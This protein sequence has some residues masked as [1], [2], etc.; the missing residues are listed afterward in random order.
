MSVL[1]RSL[2][3]N[4][5]LLYFN[6]A[7][8]ASSGGESLSQIFF[9]A[10]AVTTSAYVV[11]LFVREKTIYSI[12]NSSIVLL[13][14]AT[15]T[16]KLQ[17]ESIPLI[18][19]LGVAAYVIDFMGPSIVLMALQAG[20]N[21]VVFRE[22]YQRAVTVELVGRILAAG[23]VALI[24]KF[25]FTDLYFYWAWVL[26]AIHLISFNYFLRKPHIKLQVV[27]ER[28]TA[29]ARVKQ[30]KDGLRFVASNSLV[31][32]AMVLIVWMNSVKFL[33]EYIF[34]QSLSQNYQGKE[35]IGAFVGNLT[36]V[37]II[38]TLSAQHFFGKKLLANLSL[39]VLLAVIPTSILLFGSAAL[40]GPTFVSLLMLM[41]FFQ[42]AHR[43]IQLPVSRQCFVPVPAGLRKNINTIVMLTSAA[44]GFLISGLMTLLAPWWDLPNFIVFTLFVAAAILLFISNFDSFYVR[45]L[46]SYYRERTDGRW[47][48]QLPIDP[49]LDAEAGVG[50]L[51]AGAPAAPSQ[52]D[53]SYI[54]DHIEGEDTNLTSKSRML[55]LGYAHSEDPSVLKKLMNSHIQLLQSEDADEI[56]AG[57]RLLSELSLPGA[58][59]VFA[60]FMFHKDMTVRKMA[61]V[62][63]RSTQLIVEF[64]LKGTTSYTRRKLRTLILEILQEE[65]ADEKIGRLRQLAR[66]KGEEWLA[67]VIELLTEDK[68]RPL[69]ATILSCVKYPKH[70][71]TLD[72]LLE[73]LKYKSFDEALPLL[74]AFSKMVQSEH[75]GECFLFINRSL[76]GLLNSN[77][78][79]W[80][81]ERDEAMTDE[82]FITLYLQVRMIGEQNVWQL[83]VNTL[84]DL[85]QV[86]DDELAILV[87]MQLEYLKQSPIVR[88]WSYMMIKNPTRKDLQDARDVLRN[89]P[90]TTDRSS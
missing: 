20:S 7:F 21:P 13:A 76:E 80:D 16:F 71:I 4:A 32:V 74:E 65:K 63:Y 43:C 42:V 57:L 29:S 69:R 83:V 27:A 6:S 50:D 79:L 85:R 53:D 84:K 48:N 64:P 54:H 67:P 60:E 22:S 46:W 38:L 81:A 41:V 26:I 31:K 66:R 49:V 44:T 34:Y 89:I 68:G 30:I 61:R 15:L 75:R 17:P 12:Y 5:T 73:S 8:V 28:P 51:Q 39:S 19:A 36:I 9:W 24:A 11:F 47:M 2:F 18:Y 56:I 35:D 52:F 70:G 3:A 23:F 25:H 58:G 33:V 45:N 10:S 90:I 77:Y 62:Y 1:S 72:P 40:M 87:D 86:S 55:L 59:F 14:L 37:I 82:F 78:N 88:V